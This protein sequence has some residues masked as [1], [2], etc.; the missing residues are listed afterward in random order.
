MDSNARSLCGVLAG[1][2][3]A[4]CIVRMGD[5]VGRQWSVVVAK[6]CSTRRK[7]VDFNRTFRRRTKLSSCVQGFKADLYKA[8]VRCGPKYARPKPGPEAGSVGG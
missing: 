5:D 3:Y 8:R 4:P 7:A 1:D 6:A 2:G